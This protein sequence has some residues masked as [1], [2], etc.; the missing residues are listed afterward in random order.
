MRRQTNTI[1]FSSELPLHREFNSARAKEAGR[2]KLPIQKRREDASHSE[3][4]AKAI[5]SH[6]EFRTKCFGVR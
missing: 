2:R 5:A 1:N 4:C 6:Q 3:S